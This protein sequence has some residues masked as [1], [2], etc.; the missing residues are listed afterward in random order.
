MTRQ[1]IKKQRNKLLRMMNDSTN[2]A[3]MCGLAMRLEVMDMLLF[4]LDNPGYT[5][6]ER[7]NKIERQTIQ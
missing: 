3:S 5:L 7:G 4:E 2:D 6:D 1:D